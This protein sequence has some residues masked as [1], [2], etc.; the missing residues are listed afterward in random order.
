MSKRLAV[1]VDLGGT[2][3]RIGLANEKGQFIAK[4]IEETQKTKGPEGVTNQIIRMIRS[5]SKQN[6]G[7]GTIVGIGIG[8][9]G[10]LD[11]D[12]GGLVKP[13]NIPF[14][15]VPLVG[16]L[17]D[18]FRLPTILLNDCTTAAM[19]ERYYGAGKGHENLVYIT[20][21]TGIG[22]G[23]Y[24]DGH[25]LVGKDGNAAEIGHF[26]ID[27]ERRLTCGCGKKGHWEAY[28]S[29]RGIP[30]YVR[31]ILKSKS[32]KEAENSLLLKMANGD[33]SKLTA[34]T[35]YDAAKT[36]DNLALECAEKIAIFNVAGFACV[37]D[38]YDP[39]LITVGG[40]IALNN[41]EFV[42]DPIGRHVGDYARNQVPEIRITPLGE[43]VV[44]YGALAMVFHP[45]EY[46]K[47]PA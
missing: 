3:I 9:T 32:Q 30:N 29:G 19:G 10:P 1:G 39:S 37:I 47:H 34:K 31:L 18:E 13:T 38:A 28:C 20:L 26:T 4:L 6:V 43:D 11:M 46:E 21:S 2:H 14:D 12:K 22:G 7:T 17:K 45:N 41:R 33:M 42:I 27:H 44:V 15:F 24:V 5:L 36:G 23:I 25:L 16:P 35:L 40:A 8:S